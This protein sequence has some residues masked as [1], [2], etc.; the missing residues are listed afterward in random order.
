MKSKKERTKPAP[1]DTALQQ[2][3]LEEGETLKEMVEWWKARESA[4]IEGAVRRPLFI[5]KTRNTGIRINEVILDRALRKA[6]Q[7]K[8]KTG[9][10]LSQLVEWLLWLY[11][12]SPMDIV[13]R[14]TESE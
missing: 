9:G 14:P 8:L 5:G 13:E 3:I 12:G 11:A 7:E 1:P 2:W 6:R 10:S 4:A